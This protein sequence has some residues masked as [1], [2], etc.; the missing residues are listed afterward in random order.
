MASRELATAE[1]ATLRLRLLKIAARVVEI[2]VWHREGMAAKAKAPRETATIDHYFPR[3]LPR[4]FNVTYLPKVGIVDSRKT[5][6]SFRHTFK[7]GLAMAGVAR[8]MRD[9]LCGHA[10]NSAGAAYVHGG[11][12]EAM[13]AAI[14]LLTFDGFAVASCRKAS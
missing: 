1:F 13:K 4:R 5:W 11:S 6:H 12:V 9:Q 3:Y 10:D 7:T 14:E 8:D 2:P